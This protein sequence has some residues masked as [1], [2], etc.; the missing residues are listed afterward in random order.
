VRGPR[1]CQGRPTPEQARRSAHRA[2]GR[3]LRR[4]MSALLPQPGGVLL[5]R[6]GLDC[7]RQA[8]RHSAA[9]QIP[10]LIA[11]S[12]CERHQIHTGFEGDCE[13]VVP[14]LARVALDEGSLIVKSSRGGSVKD[15]WLVA[16]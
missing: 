14:G 3:T 5:V 11:R 8:L 6:D 10:D 12:F 15:T 16:E 7:G 9:G 4:A 13:H 1:A 2:P